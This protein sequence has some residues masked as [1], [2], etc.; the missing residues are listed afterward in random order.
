MQRDAFRGGRIMFGDV[1]AQGG[2]I[3]NG[4]RGPKE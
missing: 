1:R 2:E 4:V 3:V